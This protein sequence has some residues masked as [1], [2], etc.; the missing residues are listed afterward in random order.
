MKQD[1]GW[2]DKKE[3]SVGALSARLAGDCACVQGA[4]GFPL[5]NIIQAVTNFVMSISIG[6]YYSWELALICLCTSPFMVGS[7]IFEAK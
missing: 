5:S 1:I 3:N 7:I 4:I 2:F 6:F